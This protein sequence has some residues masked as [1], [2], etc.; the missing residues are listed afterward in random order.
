[1]N[2]KQIISIVDSHKVFFKVI[3]GV[4]N[5]M[6]FNNFFGGIK[7]VDVGLSLL[8]G[9]KIV[10]RGQNNQIVIGNY[11]RLV[12]CMITIRGN[13]NTIVIGDKCICRQAT[14]CIEDDN[15]SIEI[16]EGTALCGQIQL[17]AIEGTSI[18]IGRGYLFSSKIDIRTGDSHSL[19]QQGTRKRINQSAS[20]AI[21]DHVW[22][23][24]GV[25]ILKGTSIAEN[26][27]VGAASLLCRSYANPHCVI[28]GVPAKEVKYDI[29]WLAERI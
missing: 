10:N 15:N 7:K 8:R 19:I 5:K 14:F 25:T 22:I 20:I 24:T 12:D 18:R 27:M 16:G 29:D 9:C 23:G 21:G 1:M 6:P 2:K 28:A 3:F 13:N 11:S 4:L 26:C 17:A